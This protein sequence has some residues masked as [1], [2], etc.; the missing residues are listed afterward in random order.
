MW[1]VG[2]EHQQ[3]HHHHHHH[4]RPP[5]ISNLHL[6]EE[7]DEHA[8]ES[9]LGH[10]FHQS[11][12]RSSRHGAAGDTQN[13]V[14]SSLLQQQQQR[15]HDLA[16]TSS[17]SPSSAASLTFP[18]LRHH[19]HGSRNHGINGTTSS[20]SS[21]FR[22]GG[23]KPGGGGSSGSLLS[24]NPDASRKMVSFSGGGESERGGGSSVRTMFP[25]RETGGGGGAYGSENNGELFGENETLVSPRSHRF[26]S[27]S[28]DNNNNNNG[29][30]LLA[31]HLHESSGTENGDGGV[32]M[33]SFGGATSPGH[34]SNANNG[35]ITSNFSHNNNSHNKSWSPATAALEQLVSPIPKS[36]GDDDD[37]G[38][39]SVNNNY[40]LSSTRSV[41]NGG[42][43]SPFNYSFDEMLSG[44]GGGITSF[45]LE[46]DNNGSTFYTNGTSILDTLNGTSGD[47]S[48]V[49]IRGNLYAS[50]VPVM[51]FF[52]VLA[53]LVNLLIVISARWCRKPMSPTLYFSISLALADAYAAGILATGLVINSLL[54]FVFGYQGLPI[55]LSLVVEAFR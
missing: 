53:V 6:G 34:Y 46:N 49:S 13:N 47:T 55:C 35:T 20:T 14:S 43:I 27:P 1:S 8:E 16:S 31:D 50:I 3:Q 25:S 18:H 39:G 44:G 10:F 52:C 9:R 33:N 22:F 21:L 36:D 51:L 17:P 42:H 30:M 12:G 19:H 28:T 7:G 45:Q 32:S 4:H 48:S 24:S 26:L 11:R 41:I 37:D 29:G 15:Y 2:L 23:A 54:P 38:S 5:H 40:Y